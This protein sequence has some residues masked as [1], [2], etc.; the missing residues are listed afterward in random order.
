MNVFGLAKFNT[1]KMQK[2][3]KPQTNVPVKI[4]HFKVICRLG[5][6]TLVSAYKILLK[7]LQKRYKRSVFMRALVM[8]RVE[9][10]S[11]FN[12]N[13]F[14]ACIGDNQQCYGN[15]ACTV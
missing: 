7:N 5:S 15:Q 14:F 8:V 6:E 3:S 1:S 2:T 11:V 10:Q 9:Q 4:C 13:L 12:Q